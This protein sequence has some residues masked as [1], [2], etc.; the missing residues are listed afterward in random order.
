MTAAIPPPIS[1]RLREEP[2]LAVERAALRRRSDILARLHET[3]MGRAPWPILHR[4]LQTQHWSPDRL[5]ALQLAKLRQILD[6]AVRNCPH[7]AERLAASTAGFQDLDDLQRLPLLSRDEVRRH[8]RAMCWRHMP[9]RRLVDYSR[10][11]TDEP[12]PYYWDRRRQAWDK[13]NRLRGHAWQGFSATD[14]ELHLW[15]IDP[16]VDFGGQMRLWLRKIRDQLLDDVQIDCLDALGEGSA[17]V[18]EA[19]RRFDP[20]RLTAYPSVLCEALG[21]ARQSGVH[22]GSSSLRCV[23]LTGEV[24]F[25]WQRELIESTLA[26]PTAQTY[27]VQELGAIAFTCPRGGWH[28]CAESAIVEVIRHHRPA[29]PGEL[30]E[31][32]VT[33]LESRAMPMIRYCTGDIVRAARDG[34]SCGLGLPCLPAIL[35]RAGDFLETQTGEWL[36]PA[37]VVACLGDLLENGHFQVLQGAGGG[38]EVRVASAAAEA[39]RLAQP[40]GQAIHGLLG[41]LTPCR[42]LPVAR[43]DRSPFGK[44]RY[45]QSDRTRM[46]LAL[47]PASASS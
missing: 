3:I 1:L 28:L 8:G 43:L 45:V 15:P 22:F 2:G 7:H 47:P 40:I 16:P 19:W 33:G 46:G 42:V 12:L 6:H 4:L 21:F 34:C 24:T 18:S 39:E 10:G 27:G 11:S 14:R 5:A 32:V 36:E 17:A 41:E 37:A 25:D 38:V 30:G 13:A 44:L 26:V 35:G 23:F 9:H 29:G 20:L 31:V